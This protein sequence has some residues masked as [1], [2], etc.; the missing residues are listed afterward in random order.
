MQNFRSTTSQPRLWDCRSSLCCRSGDLAHLLRSHARDRLSLPIV[1]V[2]VRNLFDMQPVRQYAA[3]TLVNLL[4]S[5][6]VASTQNVTV[7]RVKTPTPT[8]TE[9]TRRFT[10]MEHSAGKH[11]PRDHSQPTASSVNSKTSL[12]CLY[13]NCER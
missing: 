5:T 2:T 8:A 13:F 9:Q 11:S 10:G 4:E 3:M 6:G 7:M 12:F 1:I